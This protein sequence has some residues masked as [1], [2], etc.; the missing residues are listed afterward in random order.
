[1]EYNPK[2]AVYRK[3]KEDAKDYIS[4]YLGPALES[5]KFIPPPVKVIKWIQVF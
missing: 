4:S 1:M 2:E 3:G 5:D